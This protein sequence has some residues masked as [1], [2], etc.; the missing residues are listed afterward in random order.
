M[1]DLYSDGDDEG[2]E[3]RGDGIIVDRGDVG[4]WGWGGGSG[5]EGLFKEEKN[6]SANSTSSS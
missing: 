1:S 3:G 4:I 5:T 2:V 6:L